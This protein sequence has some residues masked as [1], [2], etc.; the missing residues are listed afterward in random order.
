MTYNP[1][2]IGNLQRVERHEDYEYLVD[3]RLLTVS[4]MMKMSDAEISKFAATE[5]YEDSLDRD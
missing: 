2:D 1:G 4:E 5:R 3:N